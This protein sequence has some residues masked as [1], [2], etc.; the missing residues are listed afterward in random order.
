MAS[1]YLSH[2]PNPWGLAVPK[3]SWLKPIQDFDAD[4]RIYPSQK[5]AIYIVGRVARLSGGMSHR[6]FKD[7]PG[8]HPDTKVLLTEKLVYVSYFLPMALT[9]ESYNIVEQLRGRDQWLHGGGTG[10]DAADKVADLLD[11]RDATREAGLRQEVR[12]DGKLIHESARI[13]LLY[14]TGGRVSL[15]RP[16][17]WAR[18]AATDTSPSGSP[19][20][21]GSPA[22]GS[23]PP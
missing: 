14:R 4:L 18:P 6:T 15:V 1:I 21:P 19:P 20:T 3:E 9:A 12:N 11:T 8:V 5:R 22:S 13:S 23:T 16:P 17:K 2:V 7:I 10:P